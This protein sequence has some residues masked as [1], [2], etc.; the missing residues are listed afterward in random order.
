MHGIILWFRLLHDCREM[1]IYTVSLPAEAPSTAKKYSNKKNKFVFQKFWNGWMQCVE[2]CSHRIL[3][4]DTGIAS[5]PIAVFFIYDA[6]SSF[7][8]YC[9]TASNLVLKCN[10]TRDHE[11]TSLKQSL[12]EWSPRLPREPQDFMESCQSWECYLGKNG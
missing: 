10:T 7:A 6:F 9:V 4:I 11:A 3:V 5:F 2:I 12:P 8:S 1:F